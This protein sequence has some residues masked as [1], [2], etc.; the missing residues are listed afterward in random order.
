LRPTETQ[1]SSTPK[2][3]GLGF[4]LIVKNWLFYHGNLRNKKLDLAENPSLIMAVLSQKI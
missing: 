1:A 4:L 2:E 3:F